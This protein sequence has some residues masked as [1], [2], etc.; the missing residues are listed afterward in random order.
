MTAAPAPVGLATVAAMSVVTAEVTVELPVEAVV[1]LVRPVHAVVVATTAPVLVMD[2]F[3]ILLTLA[4]TRAV[5]S[6]A[7]VAAIFN[8]SVP[9]PPSITSSELKVN[10]PADVEPAKVSLPVPPTNA[11]P[12]SIPVVSDLRHGFISC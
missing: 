3:S 4:P 12:E 9:A 7:T 2:A 8:V 10:A 11:E 6:T 1:K 5:V